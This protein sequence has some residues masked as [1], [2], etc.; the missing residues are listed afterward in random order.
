MHIP[1]LQ[2]QVF[3]KLQFTPLN[4]GVIL[5]LPSTIYTPNV[6]YCLDLNP[7]VHIHC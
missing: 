4:F 1:T 3:T 2:T 6:T 7:F 5:I